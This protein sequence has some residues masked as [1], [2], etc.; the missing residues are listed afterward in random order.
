MTLSYG[1]TKQLNLDLSHAFVSDFVSL[2]GD[3]APIHTNP[4]FA[5]SHGFKDILVH[6]AAIYSLI[7]GFFTKCIPGPDYFCLSVNVKFHKP[8]YITDS[9]T[10]VGVVEQL[11]EA[12]GT[13]SLSINVFSVDERLVCSAKSLHR[14]ISSLPSS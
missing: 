2:S 8:L 3:D 13:A 11:S 14:I 10:I 9:I 7:S 5:Q 1:L 12:T 4:D 6:G